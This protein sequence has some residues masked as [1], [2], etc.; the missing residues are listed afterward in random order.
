MKKNKDIITFRH[1]IPSEESMVFEEI[2]PEE[3]RE[4]VESR[5]ELKKNGCEFIH[6]CVDGKPV[7]ETYF[8]PLYK[9]LD[10]FLNDPDQDVTGLQRYSDK[11]VVYVHSFATLPEFQKMGYGTLLKSYFLGYVKSKEYEYVVGHSK[12]GSIGINLGFGAIPIM[13]IEDWYGTNEPVCLYE[14]KIN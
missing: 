5:N 3:L 14:I 13:K 8:I 6:L 2:F 9:I 4:D 1:D 10:D 11:N 7:S 12:K